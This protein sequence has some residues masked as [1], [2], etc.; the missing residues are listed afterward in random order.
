MSPDP[1][2][3]NFFIASS[4]EVCR[5]NRAALPE[6]SAIFTGKMFG[7]MFGYAWAIGGSTSR[8]PLSWK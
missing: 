1:A 5:K 3:S 8:N 7:S 2:A 4:G 6:A